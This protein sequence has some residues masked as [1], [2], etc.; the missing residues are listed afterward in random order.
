MKYCIVIMLAALW[1][2][3][4][5]GNATKVTE[6]TKQGVKQKQADPEA[7]KVL[8]SAFDEAQQS[9]K[10]I[11]S[12]AEGHVYFNSYYEGEEQLSKNVQLQLDDKNEFDVRKYRIISGADSG[13]FI[14]VNELSLKMEGIDEEGK[15]FFSLKLQNN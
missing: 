12:D 9:Y 11:F 5:S 15:R 10:V 3:S 4:C 2:Y 14:V 1:L 13:K 8:Y 6:E 7:F